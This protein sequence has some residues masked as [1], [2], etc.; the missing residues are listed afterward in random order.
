VSQNVMAKDHTFV[1]DQPMIYPM[2]MG[3]AQETAG[4]RKSIRKP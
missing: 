4:P 3:K 1:L 2:V